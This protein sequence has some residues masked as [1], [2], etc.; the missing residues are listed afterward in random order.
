MGPGHR[1]ASRP[2]LAKVLLGCGVAYPLLYV[3]ESDTPRLGL[4]ERIMMGAWLLWMA[5]L[6]VVL[7]RG[8]RRPAR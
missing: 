4:F 7:L 3:I 8:P 6:A 5:V 1:G 2:A